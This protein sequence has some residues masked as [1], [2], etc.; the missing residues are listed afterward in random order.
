MLTKQLTSSRTPSLCVRIPCII[1]CI[2][3]LVLFFSNSIMSV[4]ILQDRAKHFCTAI[5]YLGHACSYILV[6]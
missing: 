1:G 4:H 6:S 2:T 5:S 3:H